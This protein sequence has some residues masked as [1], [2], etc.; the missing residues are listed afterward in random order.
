MWMRRGKQ[1]EIPSPGQNKK[2]IAF[3]AIN[4]GTGQHLSHVPDVPKGG[5]NSAQFL[6][7]LGKLLTHAR[8]TGRRIILALDNGSIH[9]AKKV[10]DVLGTADVRKLIEVFWLPKYA[11]DLNEQERVWKVAKEQGVANVLFTNRD[12]L[13]EHVRRVLNSVNVKSGSTLVIALGRRW[14]QG[15]VPKNFVTS[16]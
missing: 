5:K 4:Y 1:V 15:R 7:F 11:P 14:R 13:R 10:K 12:S 6:I 8:R 3:G 16:A 2:V 9:T